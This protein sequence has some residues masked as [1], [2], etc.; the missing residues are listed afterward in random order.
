[1]MLGI[2]DEIIHVWTDG[3]YAALH[4]W[5][6]VTLALQTNTLAHDGTE[7]QAGNAGSS[8]TMHASQIAAKHKNLVFF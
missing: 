7:M 5:D 4:R 1:M 6:G 3:F 8:T 2:G